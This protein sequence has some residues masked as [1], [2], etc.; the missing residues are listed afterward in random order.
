MDKTYLRPRDV[1]PFA[2]FLQD[3]CYYVL[4]GKID[5]Y[6][7]SHD[8]WQTL[9]DYERSLYNQKS[10]YI[11]ARIRSSGRAS[12]RQ[13]EPLPAQIKMVI[14]DMYRSRNKDKFGIMDS[15]KALGLDNRLSDADHYNEI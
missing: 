2:L 6:S 11:K 13:A 9:T 5:P 12:V 15:E 14:F 8:F 10:Q 4:G 7:E 1:K 3:L